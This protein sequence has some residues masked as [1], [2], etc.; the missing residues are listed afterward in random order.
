MASIHIAIK[1]PLS[2][3]RALCHFFV[4]WKQHGDSIGSNTALFRVIR[5]G[6]SDASPT[7]PADPN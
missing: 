4:G 5:L 7:E 2:L 3:R 6:D 1:Y